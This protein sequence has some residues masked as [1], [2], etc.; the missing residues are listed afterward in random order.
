MGNPQIQVQQQDSISDEE[1]EVSS[2]KQEETP[3]ESQPVARSPVKIEDS[4][5][6]K[7]KETIEASFN[8]FSQSCR[9][10]VKDDNAHLFSTTEKV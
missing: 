8:V 3:Q 2:F 1:Q 6:Q 9:D 10:K 4:N 7:L 5:T